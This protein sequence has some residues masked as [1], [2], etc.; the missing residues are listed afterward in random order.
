MYPLSSKI[1]SKLLHTVT[2]LLLLLLFTCLLTYLPTVNE[3]S[4]GGSSPYTTDKINMN[5]IYINETVQL[6][7]TNNTK[8]SKYKYKYHQNTNTIVTSPTHYTTI[9]THHKIRCTR[10]KIATIHSS[11][12]SIRSQ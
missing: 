1:D 6:H 11:A 5:K 3:F 4:P 9:Q 7:S 10:S 12:L 8:H 2:V